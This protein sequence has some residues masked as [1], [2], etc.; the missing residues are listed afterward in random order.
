[1][2]I[3]HKCWH[4]LGRI[5]VPNKNISWMA[6]VTGSSYAV[7]KED[8]AFF[9]IYITGRDNQNRSRI[10]KATFDIENLENTISINNSPVLYL[11]EL[12]CFDENG[13]SYPVIIENNNLRY[14]YYVGWVPTVLTPFQNFTGLAIAPLGTD[15]FTRFSRAPILERTNEEPFSVGSVDVMYENGL[16]RMWYTCFLRWGLDGEHK[17]Y[18]V[19]KYAESVDGFHWKRQNKICIN[20]KDPAEYAIGKPSVFKY[21]NRYYM[22]YVYRGEQYRIGFAISQDGITWE[23]M[24]HLAGIDTSING[25]DSIA[26]SYPHVFRYKNKLYMLYCGNDYGREGLGIAHMTLPI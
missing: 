4:K 2:L 6:T 5:L 17:H 1:M 22:W 25:W 12:G 8:T 23:R 19:I 7:Q 15:N 18:Y 10:G 14:M 16:W 9:D 11:G 20:I 21:N 26:I 13:V 3:N 24:D